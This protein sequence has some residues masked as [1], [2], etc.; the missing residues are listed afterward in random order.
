MTGFSGGDELRRHL[1]RWVA[2]GLIDATQ[3]ARIEAAEAPPAT[4]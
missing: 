2:D 3:A 4:R 1:D